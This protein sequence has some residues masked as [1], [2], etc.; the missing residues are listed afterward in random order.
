[1]VN[2]VSATA[3]WAIFQSATST[4]IIAEVQWYLK[5]YTMFKEYKMTVGNLMLKK[6]K[7]GLPD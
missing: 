7:M 2:Y 1:M 5:I 6:I 4:V 3:H